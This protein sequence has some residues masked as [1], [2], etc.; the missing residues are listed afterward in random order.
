M[1]Q[2]TDRCPVGHHKPGTKYNDAQRRWHRAS[3]MS[4]QQVRTQ[5]R[6]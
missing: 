3:L 2:Y 5:M 1:C 6:T 4:V